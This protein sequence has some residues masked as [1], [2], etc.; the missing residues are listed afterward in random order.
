MS[1]AVRVSSVVV[2]A[3]VL[4]ACA[5]E[6]AG[7]AGGEAELTL[8]LGWVEPA[9]DTFVY[10]VPYQDNNFGSETVLLV[11]DDSSALIR[12]D[13]SAIES[14]SHGPV[15]EA[16]IR[17]RG[18]E[19]VHQ[20]AAYRVTQDPSANLSW[21]ELGAT[22]NCPHDS[23]LST[24]GPQCDAARGGAWPAASGPA[25]V[26]APSDNVTCD[27]DTEPYCELDVTADVNAFLAGDSPNYGWVIKPGGIAT[28]AWLHSREDL[29]IWRR[30][31]LRL[32][33][34]H[35][36]NV[37]EPC[38]APALN[39][40]RI[41]RVADVIEHV[42]SG[43]C[44]V[45]RGADE[46]SLDAQ[47]V[48]LLQGRVVD[49]A[50]GDPLA[51]VNVRIRSHPEV[52]YTRSR[53]DGRW[54]LVTNGGGNVVV[55][56][57]RAAVP[58]VSWPRL[59]PVEREVS[60]PANDYLDVGDI[61][62]LPASE[63]SCVTVGAGGGQY[64]LSS[65]TDARGTRRTALY[66]PAGVAVTDASGAA[67][68]PPFEVCT[69]EYTADRTGGT[70]EAS[71][72][73]S[74]PP[75]SAFTFAAEFELRDSMGNRVDSP[76]FSAPV[77]VYVDD[78]LGF[79]VADTVVPSGEY[80]EGESAW[81]AEDDGRVVEV[82]DVGGTCWLDVTG[83]GSPDSSG[84]G[85]GYDVTPAERA[86]FGGCS[87]GVGFNG[88]D[89]LWRIPLWGFSAHDF[90]W[91][92]EFVNGAVFPFLEWVSGGSPSGS[93]PLRNSIVGC[94]AQSL[95]EPIPVTGTPWT[96]HYQSENQRG[97]R[98]HYAVRVRIGETLIGTG[99]RVPPVRTEVRV[100]VAGQTHTATISAGTVT[101]GSGTFAAGV[102]TLYWDGRDHWGRLL[103][104]AQPATIEVGNVY[105]SAQYT[106]ASTGGGRSFE[107][108]GDTSITG[109]ADE[110][111]LWSRQRQLVGG[112]DE[113]PSPDGEVR[114]RG[115]GGWSISPHHVYDAAAGVLYR[116]NGTR[117]VAQGL[118]ERIDTY[119]NGTPFTRSPAAVAVAPDG[120]V[121][122][123]VADD[124][125]RLT[126]GSSTADLYAGGG[127]AP[128]DGHRLAAG[129]GTIADLVTTRTGDLLVLEEVGRLR[130]IRDDIVSTP[131][132]SGLSSPSEMAVGP[133]G[134]VFIADTF[135]D[136]IQAW[137]PTGGTFT[138][139]SGALNRPTGIAVDGRGFVYVTTNVSNGFGVGLKAVWR[140][141]P[142]G[143]D[144]SRVTTIAGGRS[145]ANLF[146]APAEMGDGGLATE[147]CFRNPSALAVATDGSVFVADDSD[148]RVRRIT[149]QGTIES[150]AG[151]G[152]ENTCAEI[153]RG[154]GGEARGG[155]FAGVADIHLGANGHLYVAD[156]ND[157]R[158]RVVRPA[159]PDAVVG[160]SLVQD[161]N[162]VHRF[163]QYGR[164]TRT[165][166]A[167]TGQSLLEFDYV[168]G[169]RLAAVRDMHSDVRL[170]VVRAPDDQPTQLVTNFGDT[171]TLSVNAVTGF[172]EGVSH[173]GSATHSFT[174]WTGANQ[175]GLLRYFDAPT[176]R[177]SLSYDSDGRLLRDTSPAGLGQV[178]LQLTRTEC[179]G[180]GFPCAP[181]ESG[182]EVNADFLASGTPAFRSRRHAI[183][184]GGGT[185]ERVVESP[186]GARQAWSFG[187]LDVGSLVAPLGAAGTER[188]PISH[189]TVGPGGTVVD[190]AVGADP[191][192]GFDPYMRAMRVQLPSGVTTNVTIERTCTLAACGGGTT[193]GRVTDSIV[194]TGGTG[195]RETTVMTEL[196]PTA[197]ICAGLAQRTT[198]TSP[199]GRQVVG[200]LDN[201]GRLTRLE[202]DGLEP[203]VVA[204][205]PS[206]GRP[207][208]VQQGGRAAQLD[209]RDPTTLNDQ[210]WLGSAELTS[211][212]SSL[213]RMEVS[214]NA[215]GYGTAV[216]HDH[217]TLL[218]S[219]TVGLNPDS[220]G[221][222]V[223]ITP[224]A[225]TATHAQ[226][227]TTR[228]GLATY[229][230]PPAG[231]SQPGILD[232]PAFNAAHRPQQV[233]VRDGAA[234]TQ[235]VDFTYESVQGYG[236]LSRIDM[237]G[238][239]AITIVRD[240]TTTPDSAPAD[241]RVSELTLDGTT[242]RYTYD[243][244]RLH[245]EEWL[246]A[247]E[248]S[249]SA[250]VDGYGD[251]EALFSLETSSSECTPGVGGCC[252]RPDVTCY[253]H[254]DDGRPIAAGDLAIGYSLIGT[255]GR[256]RRT[257]SFPAGPIVTSFEDFNGYGELDGATYGYGFFP[258]TT[259]YDYS[260]SSRDYAGRELQ[261]SE[262]VPGTTEN[263]S[264]TYDGDGRLDTVRLNGG[265]VADYD[266]DPNGNRTSAQYYGAW[267]NSARPSITSAS[268]DEQDRLVQSSACQYGYT[269]W[270]ALE[271]RTCGSGSAEYEYDVLGN[272]LSVTL[273]PSGDVVEYDVDAMGRRVARRFLTG[274]TTVTSEQR[275]LYLG[276][277]SPIAELDG[278]NRIQKVFVYGTRAN[279]P[280]YYVDSSGTIYRFVTDPRGTV[281]QVLNAST[282]ATV[283]TIEYD[284]YGFVLTDSAPGLQP[285]GFAG[286]I[287]DHSTGLV[288]F[289]ARDYDAS[290]GRW[291]A[292]DPLLFAP[293]SVNLYEYAGGD[294]INAVDPDGRIWVT[295]GIVVGGAI[296]N[297]LINGAA[298]GGQVYN[299]GGSYGDGFRAGF[300]GGFVGGLFGGVAGLA[301]PALGG[302]A[303]GFAT[304]F[305]T[306]LL[307]PEFCGGSA[308]IGDA[309]F[310]GAIGGASGAVFGALGRGAFQARV[311]G[312]VERSILAGSSRELQDFVA[313]LVGETLGGSLAG[314]VSTIRGAGGNQQ[315]YYRPPITNGR[316]YLRSAP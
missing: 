196:F 150:I 119:Y 271:W 174:Y 168:I 186:L 284:A 110:I 93:C 25:H 269:D 299:L 246:G 59:L 103:Q 26:E 129:F 2:F 21:S 78:F 192:P 153:E 145:C 37:P 283:Q 142:A 274:G 208:M 98:D 227:F 167:L 272:L 90:N 29:D 14:I 58:S 9:A 22:W 13:T 54:E 203:I 74:L 57:E 184:I 207:S 53:E 244:T 96:L 281:R 62:M 175:D 287:Y 292:R 296:I 114:G 82:I 289:G 38:P 202:A 259:L 81:A 312:G 131:I 19:A 50:T 273:W 91:A 163:D 10:D 270:G 32:H 222:L 104:G 194:A 126:P 305:L 66:F 40:T 83:D 216:T 275:Y 97:R 100:Q 223:G 240:A 215:A 165:E 200:C 247:V 20:L 182:W 183:R 249:V 204:Y 55:D 157:Q 118:Q 130:R 133:T 242:T 106:T 15:V 252:S 42:H 159:L 136:R 162:V 311:G 87:G 243:G 101:A 120:T 267:V 149:P 80:V 1:V 166:S 256:W 143:A 282:G 176:G 265:L 314:A 237:P 69:A 123:A 18:Y 115:L 113:G 253:S 164:H 73:S 226:S 63:L 49:A 132:A 302:A 109:T 258:F 88:G 288:R 248:G 71:M 189:R 209:Y 30:P 197:G 52:G 6:T 156:D 89:V 241:G 308:D 206:T 121:F 268:Y 160:E 151:T 309:L 141:A 135:N 99:P 264:Y 95:G 127:T 147:A 77:F 84:Y 4:C 178:D 155:S 230:P 260:V 310:A 47:R 170:D 102:Y 65:E 79:P 224:A 300:I 286:G 35:P 146:C 72:P 211:L 31:I 76:T 39:D 7:V 56:F 235:Q 172:L 231:G 181:E 16:A 276:G 116:G 24:P 43:D 152:V 3:L 285:F 315:Y 68:P 190:A 5:A 45:Q 316:G 220:I 228:D 298:T 180:V 214:R 293:G 201:G 297:G 112:W 236:Y 41:T 44:P 278:L 250:T 291:T 173:P 195:S 187:D 306:T 262:T 225:A 122:F 140:I 107:V 212:G 266:Y 257:T 290:A 171:T 219:W 61:P 255:P 234:V 199:L 169:G 48:S 254:D 111:T 70:G 75:T 239:R 238:G 277:L 34:E 307:V 188:L 263:L 86:A 27:F 177:W 60:L 221:R 245:R 8:S 304:G 94:E 303:G 85:T 158:L 134:T 92:R 301:H 154:D 280:D 138:F 251:L 313:T 125:Y 294:P 213:E 279:V 205:D 191:R 217:L 124:V 46:S 108:P 232:I 210:W 17:I 233:L 67:V 139:F 23:E 144:T 33:Y 28:W 36:Q 105:D 64:E 11:S 261:R 198:R 137:N 128:A 229:T 193:P 295:V 148:Y 179:G 185:T 12:F 161:G 117:L 51:G 218:S